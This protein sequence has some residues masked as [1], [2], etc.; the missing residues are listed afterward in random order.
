MTYTDVLYEKKDGVGWI[1]INRPRSAT[2][3]AP[4]PCTS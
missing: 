4:R 1:T 3:F 2:R